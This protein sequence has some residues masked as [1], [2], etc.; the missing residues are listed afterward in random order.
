M[1]EQEF[2]KSYD[3]TKF[4]R[5]SVAT[6][7]V[8]FT[9]DKQD[10][11]PYKI[12]FGPLQILLIQRANHPCKDLWSLPGG[13]CQPNETFEETAIRELFE[14]T[15]ISNAYLEETKTFTTKDRDPRGWIVSDAFTGIICK[16]ECTL[17]TDKEAW[18]AAWFD[19]SLQIKNTKTLTQTTQE[20]TYELTCRNDTNQLHAELCNTF[21][22]KNGRLKHNWK[23][24]R[25]DFGFDHAQIITELLLHLRKTLKNDPKM[26]FEFVP[27][28]FTIGELETVY[29]AIYEHTD[30]IPNFRR[31]INDYVIETVQKAE[32]QAFRPAKL[33]MR[34]PDAFF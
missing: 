24:I 34:N 1:T 28:Y 12:A 21:T 16:N 32:K 20:T 29:K 5:P 4:Q 30:R 31:K 9:M 19:I 17:R 8:L 22:L 10:T 26:L 3:I 25:S 15:N 33:F 18:N 7:I 13:F 23:I 2:L 11:N 14:E 27:E 6:D